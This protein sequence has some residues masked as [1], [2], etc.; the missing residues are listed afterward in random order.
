MKQTIINALLLVLT[1]TA[2]ASAAAPVPR[3]PSPA[4]AKVEILSPHD[5]ERVQS[6]VTVRFGLSGMGVAPAGVPYPNTGH[7]HLLVD[8]KLPPMDAPIPA[9][10]RHIHFGKGQTETLIEL[11]PG[12]HTLQLILG[13]QNHVPHDPPVVS[14]PVTIT[15]E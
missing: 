11:P 4:G 10:E 13:D 7:H 2:T 3:T 6:P 14:E 5:G 9:D 8:S 1:L 12:T 15:V